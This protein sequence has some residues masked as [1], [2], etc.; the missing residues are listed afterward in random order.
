MDGWKSFLKCVLSDESNFQENFSFTCIEISG[1]NSLHGSSHLIIRT[2]IVQDIKTFITNIFLIRSHFKCT[3]KQHSRFL[4][5]NF[6]T[7]FFGDFLIFNVLIFFLIFYFY[8][9]FKTSKAERKMK[10]IL[11]YQQLNLSKQQLIVSL[12]SAISPPIPA[13][14]DHSEPD[15]WCH[16]T[17]STNTTMSISKRQARTP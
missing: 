13:L 16:I 3:V 4:Q 12:I 14:L 7:F 11:L 15:R 9:I 8:G 17:S 5:N 10:L 1:L 6:L 2:L